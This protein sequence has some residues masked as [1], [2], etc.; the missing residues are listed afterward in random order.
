MGF[1]SCTLGNVNQDGHWLVLELARIRI[2]IKSGVEEDIVQGRIE[3]DVL[4]NM[5]DFGEI[6]IS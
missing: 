5:V 6:F 4:S 2:N 3:G 1:D